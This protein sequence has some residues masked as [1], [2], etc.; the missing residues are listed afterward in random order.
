MKSISIKIT[1]KGAAF[2]GDSEREVAR[3]LREIASKIE[4]G[5]EPTKAMDINGNSV[6]TVTIK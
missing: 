2:E 3:I 4:K 1:A 5:N 6:G